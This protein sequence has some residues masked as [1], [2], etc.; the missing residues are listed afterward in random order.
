[1]MNQDLQKK[2]F[3]LGSDRAT[4]ESDFN[5]DKLL[6]DKDLK[7]DLAFCGSLEK[8]AD[9]SKKTEFKEGKLLLEEKKELPIKLTSE[10]KPI[11]DK[12]ENATIVIT[13]QEPT[14]INRTEGKTVVKEHY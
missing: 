8:E 11:I 9:W 7:K 14:V 2:D 6:L 3:S 13:H 12:T 1:M 4:F 10:S 5:K